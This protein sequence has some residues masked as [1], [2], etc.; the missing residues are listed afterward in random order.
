MSL[1]SIQM[2][3]LILQKDLFSV[4]LLCH[5]DSF[6]VIDLD[7]NLDIQFRMYAYVH[8]NRTLLEEEL[9]SMPLNSLIS[10]AYHLHSRKNKMGRLAVSAVWDL[11]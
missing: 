2:K 5:Q 8:A 4:V 10:E 7:P 6:A 1:I 11:D 9:G 3:R